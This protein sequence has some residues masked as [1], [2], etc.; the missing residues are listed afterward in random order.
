MTKEEFPPERRKGV[1]TKVAT[2]LSDAHKEPDGRTP[3]SARIWGTMI[4]VTV[5][6]LTILVILIVLFKLKAT[7]NVQM[8][9]VLMTSLAKL[10]LWEFLFLLATAL[11]L[12]GINVWKYVAQI[13]TGVSIPDD[14]GKGN[15]PGPM[16][17]PP[18][19]TGGN[20]TGIGVGTS[21]PQVPGL[22]QVPAPPLPAPKTPVAPAPTDVVDKTS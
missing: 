13:R 10:V 7:D 3:S 12:Y 17:Y 14:D 6:I 18:R 11:S 1:T 5:N 4:L 20:P 19:P 22:P 15:F 8:A 16:P 2:F 21:L 9:S